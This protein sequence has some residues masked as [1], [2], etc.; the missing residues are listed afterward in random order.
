MFTYFLIPLAVI[1]ALFWGT[2]ALGWVPPNS[3]GAW[4]ALAF[5]SLSISALWSSMM[6]PQKFS[7]TVFVWGVTALAIGASYL[8]VG[9][10]WWVGVAGSI[11]VLLGVLAI[12][13]LYAWFRPTSPDYFY[14]YPHPT[15]GVC[16][17]YTHGRSMHETEKE[18]RAIRCRAR[19]GS[20]STAAS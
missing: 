17:I 18:V 19:D 16:M 15:L 6:R 11:A 20:K 2:A 13:F 10:S 9:Y 1:G 7:V 12:G 4:H 3:L 8:A 14:G 5:L